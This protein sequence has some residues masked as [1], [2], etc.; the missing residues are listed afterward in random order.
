MDKIVVRTSYESCLSTIARL[1]AYATS[2]P[3]LITEVNKRQDIL[4]TDD[5]ISFCIHARRFVEN[6][7][8][9]DLLYQEMIETN[10]CKNSLSL[11]KIIGCLIHHDTFEILRC[12]TRFE[13]LE[14][15]LTGVKG[16]DFFKKIT[17]EIQ[18]PPYSQPIIPHIL[19]Q[20]D[21]SDGMRL[22]NL[23]TFLEVFSEKIL[24]EI[25]KANHWLQDN[26]FRDLD[27][28]KDD[29]RQIMSRIE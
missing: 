6:L 11:G 7:G 27:I 15:S 5:L 10:D 4:A 24:L 13:M 16:N 28:T 26:L 20:S 12:K 23:V 19:F 17:N 9:K 18:K 3:I 8:S 21:R 1:S 29:A 2:K 14:A 22:I 25:L